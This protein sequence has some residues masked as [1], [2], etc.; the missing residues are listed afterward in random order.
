ML[1]TMQERVRLCVLN[2]C[3][4]MELA[5]QLVDG[6][7]VDCAVGWRRDVSD[8]AAIAFSAALYGALGDGRNIRDAVAVARVACGTGDQ[9]VLVAAD[10]S[11]TEVLVVGEGDEP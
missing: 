9:P 2:A 3:V 10:Q 1:R 6:G 4:S 8:S 11:D 5:Q 7:A